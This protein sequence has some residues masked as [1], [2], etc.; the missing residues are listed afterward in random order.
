MVAPGSFPARHLWV[1]S[2]GTRRS[3]MPPALHM[4]QTELL[5]TNSKLSKLRA[6]GLWVREWVLCSQTPQPSTSFR[7]EKPKQ[8]SFVN[9]L[10]QWVAVSVMLHLPVLEVRGLCQVAVSWPVMMVENERKWHAI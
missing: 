1:L 6:L 3:Q 2:E 4:Q 9:P 5:R 7:D 10:I 8:N